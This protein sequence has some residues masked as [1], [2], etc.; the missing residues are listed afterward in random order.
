M[1]ILLLV[2]YSNVDFLYVQL[3]ISRV[4]WRE[5]FRNDDSAIQFSFYSTTAHFTFYTL[6]HILISA[7]S[8][9]TIFHYTQSSQF[10]KQTRLDFLS[11]TFTLQS[12]LLRSQDYITRLFTKSFNSAKQNAGRIDSIRQTSIPFNK[13]ALYE[14][15]LKL[16]NFNKRSQLSWAAHILF[17]RLILQNYIIGIIMERTSIMIETFRSKQQIQLHQR[18]QRQHIQLSNSSP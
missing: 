2:V 3:V 14:Y 8:C 10:F 5:Y 15:T 9:A 17:R 1:K 7:S 12:Q 11:T 6:P 18:A 16:K 13:S 4:H